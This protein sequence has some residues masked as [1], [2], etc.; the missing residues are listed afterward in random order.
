MKNSQAIDAA[1]RNK[2][3]EGANRA[4]KVVKFNKH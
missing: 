3:S 4:G 2:T 1:N